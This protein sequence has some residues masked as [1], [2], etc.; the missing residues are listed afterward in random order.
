GRFVLFLHPDTS[1]PEDCFVKCIEFF[2]THTDAGALGVK[3]LDGAGN[4]LKESK[5]SF[6]SPLTSLFKLFGLA[7]LFPGSKVFAKYHYGHLDENSN[8]EVDVL[9]GELIMARK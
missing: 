5:R 6:P 3:M 7:I 9:Y 4:F 8:N 2:N 1:V